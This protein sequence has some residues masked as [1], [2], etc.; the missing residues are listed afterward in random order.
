M[1]KNIDALSP[2]D[3]PRAFYVKM[4]RMSLN[5]LENEVRKFNK[6]A[7]LSHIL[8]CYLMV[9]RQPPEMKVEM[10]LDEN[11]WYLKFCDRLDLVQREEDSV[12]LI[13]IDP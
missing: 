6:Y 4:T 10:I 1:E 5:Q 8:N 11:G 13:N 9:R 3:E 7:E 2:N 12:E